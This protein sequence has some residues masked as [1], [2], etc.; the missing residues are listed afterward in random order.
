VTT[1]SLSPRPDLRAFALDRTIEQML[2]FHQPLLFPSLNAFRSDI[3]TPARAPLVS[4][5]IIPPIFIVTIFQ[6]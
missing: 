5:I 2:K 6:F 3:K 1:V 4:N